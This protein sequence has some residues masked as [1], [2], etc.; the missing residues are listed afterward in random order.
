LTR[1]SS[2]AALQSLTRTP[3]LADFRYQ[4][5]PS[6]EPA[7]T[8]AV[9]RFPDS[10]VLAATADHAMA[11]T[12]ITAEGRA[13]TEILLSVRNHA[14]PF[15]KVALPSGATIV[16]VDIAGEP[17]KPVTGEDGT[18]VPLLR[19]GFRPVGPYAV[20]F[21]FLHA[22]T[23]FG[24][25][26]DLAMTLPQMDIPIGV[27]AWEIFAPENYTLRYR[28]GNAISQA[29]L[30]KSVGRKPASSSSVN[31]VGLGGRIATSI[32][33]GEPSG[34]VRGTVKDQ[35]GA[36]IPGATIEVTSA[37]GSS[38][39]ATSVADGTFQ[40]AGL[41]RGVATVKATLP[42]FRLSTARFIVGDSGEKVDIVMELGSVAETV[43]VTAASPR[44]DQL[45]RFV[46]RVEEPPVR[47]NVD[48]KESPSQNVINLQRRV[49]GLLP[50]R[51]DVP[52]AGTA[53]RFSRPLVVNDETRV[54]FH[55]K[56]R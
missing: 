41:R 36:V 55:Y 43:T 12:L 39:V 21:V 31:Q 44:I 54:S 53:Y 28:D 24:R 38:L 17:A 25:K 50:I 16:S 9:T 13:L 56:N 4:R 29:T 8:L 27:V 14:Q 15:L 7:L 33:P 51:V 30:D 2:N 45:D 47:N 11:T 34:R 49:A 40:I 37:N 18:R 10:S 3:L 52:R 32:V 1:A 42:G 6:A 20:S 23:P 22:G 35:T 26:G 5:T 48:Q 46:W 19:P